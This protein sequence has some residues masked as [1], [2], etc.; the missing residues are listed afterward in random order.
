MRDTPVTAV[1]L[2]PAVSRDLR[3]FRRVAFAQAFF[4]GVA[5]LI[6]AQLVRW[7]VIQRRSLLTDMVAGSAYMQE[8]S[9]NRGMILDRNE[10]VLALN[11]FD[12]AIEA[13]PRWIDEEDKERVA[14]DLSALLQC[15][16]AEIRAKLV[17]DAAW[18]PI[19]QRVPRELGKE[20]ILRRL[21]GIY[22]S[23]VAVRVY[24][25][26]TLAA[27]VLGFVAGSDE[28]GTQGY[29]GVE[30]FYDDLLQGKTGL[31]NGQWDP[32]SPVSFADRRARNWTIPE[33]GRTVVLTIDRTVQ[34]LVA[35]E[36]RAAVERYGAESGSIVIVDPRTGAIL[37]SA[38]YPTY[39]PN[40]FAEAEDEVLID[41]VIGVAYEPGSTFKVVTMAAALDTGAVHPDDLYNDIGY[42]EVGG[43]I[44]RNW[45]NRAYGM[46]DMTGILVRSLNT[47]IAHVNTV[48][49]PERFYQYVNRFG[50]G[51]RTGVD[52][53]GEASGLT[54]QP[55][56][57]EWHESDLGTNAFGQGLAATPLQMAMAVG[58]VANRGVMMRPYVVE[59]LTQNGQMIYAK[60]NPAGRVISEETAKVLTEMMAQ[61]VEQGTVM[62]QVEGYRI[63]GKTGTAQTAILG[64]YGYDPN[65]TIASFVGFAPADDPRFVA[66]VKLDKPTASPWGTTTAAPTFS[67]VARIM[68]TQLEIPPDAVR[69]EMN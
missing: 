34:Y 12:Y 44:L 5:L 48:L 8:I 18:A 41:P 47:G 54:R 45:D 68:F 65:L 53:Q 6:V 17:G 39:D 27:H 42:I 49:G 40:Q 60:H 14:A 31:R 21:P 32:W 22:A 15:P 11:N 16:V 52:L 9:P 29:Y 50:F 35:Q 19:A 56:D 1:D 30:G 28:G 69:W 25:E 46:V 23:P 43:R 55:G 63:A 10:K 2:P 20:I 33:D 7:Q 4:L 36:L 26:K 57:P 24:P 3:P 59:S 67:R 37:A 66:L 62:A 51:E 64:G 13:A 58:A 61:V 38:A